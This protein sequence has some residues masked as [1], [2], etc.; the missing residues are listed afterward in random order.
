MKLLLDR[1]RKHAWEK[2]GDFR[3]W[4][5]GDGAVEL[6]MLDDFFHGLEAVLPSF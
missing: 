4:K 2:D 1:V 6:P 3:S 5:S